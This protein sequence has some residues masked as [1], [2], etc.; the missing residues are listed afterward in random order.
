MGKIEKFKE[1]ETFSCLYQPDTKYDS[2]EPFFLRGKWNEA[3]GN[4]RPI[5][6][7]A[8][9]GQGTY[10]LDMAKK[11]PELNFIGMDIKGAR[12]WHGAKIAENNKIPNVRFLRARSE[13]CG[14]F[15]A[16][17]EINTIWLTF[18]DPNIKNCAKRRRFVHP[19]F[20]SVFSSFLK[21]GG[22]IILKT[23]SDFLFEYAMEIIGKNDL[24][25]S[26][27]SEDVHGDE[28]LA[29]TDYDEI[30]TVYEKR[31]IDEGKKIKLAKFHL[32]DK[33]EFVE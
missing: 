1:N 22:S 21:K 26:L 4:N 2:V 3:F 24:R 15:F 19:F 5:I 23:D 27:Y 25:V 10:T 20:L 16:E 8:G 6:L 14:K 33:R 30:I 28:N 17:D 29:N 18:P 12:I 11:H 9:C 31:F 13:L 32:D 7:E